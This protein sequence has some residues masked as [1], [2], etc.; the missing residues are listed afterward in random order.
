[1]RREELGW[2]K[3]VK[4]GALEEK[5]REGRWERSRERRDGGRDP[6]AQTGRNWER[7]R[8]RRGL[9]RG[10]DELR[11]SQLILLIRYRNYYLSVVQSRDGA[12]GLYFFDVGKEA[13]LAGIKA[14]GDARR[15]AFLRL[16]CGWL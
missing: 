12:E 10:D 8:E 14:R 16:R 6:A 7:L 1:L 5:R 11:G 2:E 3:V 15:L 13:W 9:V 4:L